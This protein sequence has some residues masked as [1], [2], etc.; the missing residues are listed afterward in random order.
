[1]TTVTT[2][3]TITINGIDVTSYIELPDVETDQSV[4][5]RATST[6][7]SFKIQNGGALGLT[8]LQPVVIYNTITGSRF[9]A[10]RIFKLDEA[11]NGLQLDYQIECV[12]HAWDMSHPAEV[13]TATYTAQ[14]DSAIIA[15]IMADCCPSI[16][17]ST[18]V[19]TVYTFP[20][21]ETDRMTPYDAVA[22]LASGAGANWY[23]DF[24]PVNATRSGAAELLSNTGFETAGGGG[25]DVFADWTENTSPSGAITSD[26]TIYK[27]GSKSCKILRGDQLGDNGDRV[28]Q[29]V[30]VVP[31]CRYQLT[32]YIYGDGINYGQYSVRD[33]TNSAN[34]IA[35]TTVP[36]NA[37]SWN[38]VRTYFV[39][40]TGCTSARLRLF[41][42]NVTGGIAY[43]DD[44]SIQ[45]TYNAYLH[46]YPSSGETA[47][48]LL[49]NNNFEDDTAGDFDNWNDV[50][51][52]GT[53]TVSASTP[54]G[55]LLQSCQL[56][57]GALRST[58]VRQDVSV[59][60]G[61]NYTLTYWTKNDASHPGRYRLY[62]L[63]SGANIVAAT[64]TSSSADWIKDTVDFTAPINCSAVRVFF[65]CPNTSTEDAWFDLASIKLKY[66]APYDLTDVPNESGYTNYTKLACSKQAPEAN[67][68]TVK[69]TGSISETRTLG[70]ESDY[71]G[72]ITTTLVDTNITTAA[73]AQEYGDNMLAQLAATPSYE[74]TVIRPGLVAGMVI[75]LTNA[76]RS[77]TNE[78]LVIYR[79]AT[80]FLGAGYASYS[81]QLGKPKELLADLVARAVGGSKGGVGGLSNALQ[82]MKNTYEA[83]ME[84]YE[85]HTHTVPET[86]E[87][88]HEVNTTPPNS[89]HSHTG[90]NTGT[91]SAHTHNVTIKY[92]TQD[93]SHTHTTKS[94]DDT[95]PA[96]SGV[97]VRNL[98]NAGGASTVFASGAGSSHSHTTAATG[99]E[100]AHTHQVN[101]TILNGGE[102]TH[103]TG[104]PYVEP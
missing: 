59:I 3:T 75:G 76:A 83:K 99:S 50:A 46:Y 82:T 22:K 65:L 30:T 13:D 73:Q 15:S 89:A 90:G 87:H 63:T 19:D 41:A 10:G 86:G 67:R 93:L 12:D 40:P 1:M 5:D 35:T 17:C 55:G 94:G 14:T 49:L 51:G 21:F 71:G 77:L 45:I 53:I 97:G 100:Q 104:A 64:D 28:Y 47:D 56:T 16:E 8:E 27:S 92:Y 69:G 42:P 37:A 44:A 62:D 70:N 91:E 72:W 80:K 7:T 57:A 29:N 74:C 52:D 32:F 2:P 4:S 103:Y 34:I 18:F 95:G 60:S 54:T 58:S 84:E 81:L 39:A 38:Y 9:F 20:K 79:I 31:G 43:F 25:A 48:E 66:D 6:S 98:D 101:I 102:H 36:F 23:V 11:S 61:R 85:L 24:G 88:T 26:T 68:I 78:R 96:L 33:M